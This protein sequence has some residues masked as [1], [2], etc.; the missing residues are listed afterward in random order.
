MDHVLK[1]KALGVKY[2]KLKPMTE[3]LLP[4]TEQSRL[5]AGQIGLDTDIPVV[6]HRP[7]RGGAFRAVS[8]N[9]HEDFLYSSCVRY[10]T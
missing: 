9:G 4:S 6:A 7:A 2:W 5:C 3:T 10:F 1:R 8:I